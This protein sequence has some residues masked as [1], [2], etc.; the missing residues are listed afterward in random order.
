[1][2]RDEHAYTETGVAVELPEDVVDR[3]DERL[4]STEFESTTEYV[5]FVLEEVLHRLDSEPVEGEH[6]DGAQVEDRLRSLGYL[7]Q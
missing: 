4:R 1:M 5:T 3:V 2:S 6:V 7:D